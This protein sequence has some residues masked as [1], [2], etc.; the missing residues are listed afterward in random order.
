[1]S[2]LGIEPQ[3]AD[4][5]SLFQGELGVPL[6]AADADAELCTLE[7]WDSLHLLRLIML[8]ERRTGRRLSLP[9]MLEARTVRELHA[10]ITPGDGREERGSQAGR[11]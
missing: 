2:A 11:P 6:T 4:L 1:M 3:L 7:C 5:I 8:V 9:A 10:L